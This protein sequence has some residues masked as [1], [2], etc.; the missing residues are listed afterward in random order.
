MVFHV[1]DDIPLATD[2]DGF[3]IPVAD[4][5]KPC[6]NLHSDILYLGC[7]FTFGDACYAEETFPY[8]VSKTSGLTHMNAGVC[9][10]GLSQM[11]L[12]AENIIPKFRPRYVV[13]QHSQWLVERSMINFAPTH[14]GTLPNPYIYEKNG[15]FDIHKPIYVTQMFGLNVETIKHET[16][17]GFFFR[18]GLAYQLKEDWLF[19][20]AKAKL[21]LGIVN[22]PS[23]K[24]TDVEI[25]GYN[26]IYEAARKNGTKVIFLSHCWKDNFVNLKKHFAGCDDIFYANADSIMDEYLAQSKSKSFAVEFT[27]W[28]MNGKDSI[29]VDGHPNAVANRL[30]AK[31]ILPF[32]EGKIESDN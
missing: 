25:Y 19:W 5:L 32:L 26:R 1:G 9:S 22:R 11:V 24:L 6:N 7:S 13:V 8:Y 29:H 2:C 31:S 10:Y 15:K 30:I 3:R 20:G 18:E 23:T 16:P 17:L 21:T 4:T 27:H 12:V 14:Y 28:R